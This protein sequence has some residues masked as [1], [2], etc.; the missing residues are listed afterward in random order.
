MS[1][2]QEIN[3]NCLD[4]YGNTPLHLA[5]LNSSA[6]TVKLLMYDYECYLDILNKQGIA[7]R[8]MGVWYPEIIAI[9]REY[10][11]RVDNKFATGDEESLRGLGGV[12]LDNRSSMK[13]IT[14]DAIAIK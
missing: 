12:K 6:E 10:N 9:I 7:T 3:F 13:R 8:D 5:A 1:L 2:N 4:F 14:S 11:G